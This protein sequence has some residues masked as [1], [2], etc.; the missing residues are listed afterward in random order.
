MSEKSNSKYVT[1]YIKEKRN[2]IGFNVP[3]GK[4]AE[5]QALAER[6]GTKLAT[7]IQQL[8]ETELQKEGGR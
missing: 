6:K 8:L 5:Y 2:Q 3:K 7:L 1:K 4:R